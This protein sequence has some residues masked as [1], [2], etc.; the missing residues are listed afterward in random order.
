M[1]KKKAKAK[2]K[3][4][5]KK[6][7]RAKA[8]TKR[9]PAKTTKAKS[10]KKAK[11]KKKRAKITNRTMHVK[12]AREELKRNPKSQKKNPLRLTPQQT[13]FVDCLL[14]TA[15]MCGTKA[16]IAAGYSKHSAARQASALLHN[17]LVNAYLNRRKADL[18]RR[19]EITQEKVAKEMAVLAF[20]K[21]TDYL[22]WRNGK[23]RLTDSQEIP[24]C[25]V[26]AIKG[27]KPIFDKFGNSLG[28]EISFYDKVAAAKLLA[29]HL[30]MLDTK[31]REDH[32]G[33]IVKFMDGVHAEAEGLG[34]G[35]ADA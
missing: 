4:A 19:L 24:D 10:K 17:P 12:A 22:E 35:K 14:G 29:Q 23:L 27:L 21:P 26:G 25:L 11:A 28:I 32:K 2:R 9:R 6:T 33:I 15:R 16:A 3:T 1:A 30:G 5:G 20:A 7:K 18:K 34:E 31:G 13:L 8:K